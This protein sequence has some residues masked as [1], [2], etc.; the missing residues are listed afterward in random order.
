MGFVISV[1]IEPVL[2]RVHTDDHCCLAT[3][4]F[5]HHDDV[6][7]NCILLQGSHIFVPVIKKEMQIL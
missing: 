1:L 7:C 5:D 4:C 2:K 3:F 6:K